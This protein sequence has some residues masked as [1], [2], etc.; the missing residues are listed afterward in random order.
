[1][2]A[3]VIPFSVANGKVYFLF[4]TTF[5]GRRAGHLVDF[6]GGGQA[7]EG[8][9]Q[10]AM[11]EFVEET[12]TMY[13]SQHLKDAVITE[14]RVLSQICLLEKLFDRTLSE[15]PDWWCQRKV[16]DSG[17]AR[18][19]RTYFIEIDYRN[20]DDMNK[21]WRDDA[22]RRFVKR[23]ELIWIASEQLVEIF[24][25]EPHRLW[26]R[27]RQLKKAKRTIRS[28]VKSKEEQSAFEK[29][30]LMAAD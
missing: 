11:R 10:T 5:S 7:G 4:H 26:R 14:K 3:G 29:I 8:Y 24:R 18:D 28:I 30:V 17:R 19:W 20:L 21:E 15:H 23:R 1:M 2:G 16:S 9:R 6:G 13:F 12:E 22:G 27:V 25:K